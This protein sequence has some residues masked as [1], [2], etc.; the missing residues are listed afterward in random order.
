VVGIYGCCAGAILDYFSFMITVDGA[1]VDDTVDIEMAKQDVAKSR[2]L[3]FKV[4]KAV[5]SY[6]LL[7]RSLR[8]ALHK[9]A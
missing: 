9:R 8:S 5:F 3:G 2:E 7:R 6:V 4:S 1:S